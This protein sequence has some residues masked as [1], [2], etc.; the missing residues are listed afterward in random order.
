M[1]GTPLLGCIHVF[2]NGSASWQG[3]DLDTKLNTSGGTITG[4]LNL[5]SILVLNSATYGN[6]LP[7]SGVAGQV[8]FKKL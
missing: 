5:N 7:S 8:F 6:T 3:L 2:D 4:R 1:D